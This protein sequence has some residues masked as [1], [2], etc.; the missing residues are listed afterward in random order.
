MT[1]PTTV[2][3][4]GDDGGTVPTLVYGPPDEGGPHPAIVLC[5][6]GRFFEARS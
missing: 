5:A 4:R 1:T 3:L 6:E 2:M